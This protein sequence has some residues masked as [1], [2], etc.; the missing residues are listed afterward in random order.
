MAS[1]PESA[2]Q[3]GHS[4][5]C[6]TFEHFMSGMIGLMAVN[7]SPHAAARDEQFAEIESSIECRLVGRQRVCLKLR[8]LKVPCSAM[9]ATAPSA[10]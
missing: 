8:S 3:R 2:A 7:G 4:Y 5:Y 1:G 6:E 9:T 10:T